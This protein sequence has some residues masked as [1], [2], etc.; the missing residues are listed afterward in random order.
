MKTLLL[1][2]GAEAFA[3]LVV[4]Y[5]ISSGFRSDVK[6]DTELLSAK[7]HGLELVITNPFTRFYHKVVASVAGAK[8]GWASVV[9]APTLTVPKLVK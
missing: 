9:K 2:L 5:L 7:I 6:S 3:I 1:H 4:L 8:A